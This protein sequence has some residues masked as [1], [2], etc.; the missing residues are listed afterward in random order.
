MIEQC[1]TFTEIKYKIRLRITYGNSKKE[2][3]K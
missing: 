3:A 1:V 2:V